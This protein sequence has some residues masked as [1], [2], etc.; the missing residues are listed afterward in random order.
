MDWVGSRKRDWHGVVFRLENGLV[1]FLSVFGGGPPSRR[2]NCHRVYGRGRGGLCFLDLEKSR[3]VRELDEY[4][5]FSIP[6][7]Y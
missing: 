6:P 2:G 5:L 3:R 7:P 1:I 4:P